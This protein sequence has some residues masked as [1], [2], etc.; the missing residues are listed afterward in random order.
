MKNI[1]LIPMGLLVALSVRVLALGYSMSDALIILGLC[2]LT[3]L[4]HLLKEKH[5]AKAQTELKAELSSLEA[6]VE[7]QIADA[8]KEMTAVAMK[9][10][11]ATNAP[12]FRF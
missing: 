5:E 11:K 1:N 12:T 10:I 6:K 8:K 3:G 7:A 9:N 4:V 2:G